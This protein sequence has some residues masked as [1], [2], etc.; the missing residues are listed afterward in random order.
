MHDFSKLVVDWDIGNAGLLTLGEL[1]Y[2]DWH[3]HCAVTA[4]LAAGRTEEGHKIVERLIEEYAACGVPFYEA[5][6]HRLKGE[7]LLA[8]GAPMM[9]AE[10]SFRKAIAIAQ[11]QQAKSWE[12]RATLS[13]VL[14]LMKQNRRDEAR[15]TLTEIYNWFTEGF[16]TAD[17]KD[18]K[19]LLDE[20][21]S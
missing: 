10:D 6:I 3:E 12:L 19:A 13:L 1:A 9:D 8:A 21:A 14:L 2:L 15:S 16:D 20:L 4:Y 18:A 5:D 11:R 7:L 17:L